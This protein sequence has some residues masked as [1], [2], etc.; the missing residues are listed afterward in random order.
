MTHARPRFHIAIP[1]HDIARR[2][3]RD[4]LQKSIHNLDVDRH[5]EINTVIH[6]GSTDLV[7]L[8]D[9]VERE[10]M[11]LSNDTSCGVGHA[12]RSTLERVVLAVDRRLHAPIMRD[13]CPWVGEDT[14]VM[15]IRRGARIYLVVA[16][17]QIGRYLEDLDAYRAGIEQVRPQLAS[18]SFQLMAIDALRA[19]A[20]KN[21]PTASGV[22]VQRK[23]GDWIEICAEPLDALIV[24]N[25]SLE[26]VA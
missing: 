12:P 4:W 24:G 5:V 18:A 20:Q 19:F 17:A 21:R 3:C 2:S 13:N 6:P 1:V 10:G 8:F 26:Q 11:P 16:C 9:R 25:E 22:A 15:G 14:K 7:E 23:H